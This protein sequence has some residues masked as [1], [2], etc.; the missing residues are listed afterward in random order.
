MRHRLLQYYFGPKPK[1]AHKILRL[2][3]LLLGVRAM[4]KFLQAE[5]PVDDPGSNTLLQVLTEWVL[6]EGGGHQGQTWSWTRKVKTGMVAEGAGMALSSTTHT[7]LVCKDHISSQREIFTKKRLRWWR[8]YPHWL[9]GMHLSNQDSSNYT[10]YT[11]APCGH[12]IT[13]VLLG[14]PLP[15]LYNVLHI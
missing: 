15:I 13:L 12:W 4:E 10:E 3:S 6:W 9:Y 8:K 2:R 14:P 7:D 5:H 1:A 11:G